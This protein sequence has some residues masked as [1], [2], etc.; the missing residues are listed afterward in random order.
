MISVP[1]WMYHVLM[2]A[3]YSHSADKFVKMT[4]TFWMYTV[5]CSAFALA[6]AQNTCPTSWFTSEFTI[7]SDRVIS[8]ATGEGLLDDP[9]G[10]YFREVL[11]FT[12]RQ[13]AAELVTIREYFNRVFGLDFPDLDENGEAHF[14]S[15]TL[16]YFRVPFTHFATNNR[17]IA[18]GNT[19][20]RCIDVLNGGVR[21]TF[22]AGS[23]QVLR[24]TYGGPTGRTVTRGEDLLYGYYSINSCP[25][26]PF[27]IQ[28]Q[29]QVPGRQTADRYVV[30][31]N[32]LYHPQLGTGHEIVVFR[33]EPNYNNDPSLLRSRFYATL[34]FP[35]ITPIIGLN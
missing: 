34:F 22:A 17:W 32:R 31:D 30:N 4:P 26:Q 24:G 13:I 14:E 6:A 25:Q 15:A 21:V 10:T 7:V 33:V 11:G 18:N 3:T 16:S 19:R 27:L 1:V 23:T 12:E 29:S 2:L 5:L 28:Y 20:S 9:N 8:A 35:S